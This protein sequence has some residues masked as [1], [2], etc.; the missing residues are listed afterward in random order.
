M[1]DKTIDVEIECKK[2][3]F[4]GKTAEIEGLQVKKACE[5]ISDQVSIYD[6]LLFAQESVS[7]DD[8][9][10]HISDYIDDYIDFESILSDLSDEKKKQL[11]DFLSSQL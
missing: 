4:D 11:L 5:S 8:M 7:V 3:S 6:I 10:S 2:I 9:R 1:S